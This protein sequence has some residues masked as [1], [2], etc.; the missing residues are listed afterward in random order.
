[1]KKWMKRIFAVL[2]CFLLLIAVTVALWWP[3][4]RIVMGT[5]ELDEQPAV[6]PEIKIAHV[7]EP[8]KESAD[9]PS[10]QQSRGRTKGHPLY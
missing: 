4:V 9:W 5:E 3:S 7:T 6:V 10:W 2:A 1:M 8:T